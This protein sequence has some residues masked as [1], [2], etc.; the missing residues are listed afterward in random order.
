MGPLKLLFC[1]SLVTQKHKSKNE[2]IN[3]FVVDIVIYK[4]VSTEILETS[5]FSLMILAHTDELHKHD[6]DMQFPEKYEVGI[7]LTM[8]PEKSVH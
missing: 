3:N 6:G 8:S 5:Y 7:N 4:A 2:C 1:K